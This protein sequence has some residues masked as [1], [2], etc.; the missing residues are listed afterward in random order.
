MTSTSGKS[1]SISSQKESG[2]SGT[3][4]LRELVDILRVSNTNVNRQSECIDKQS[5]RIDEIMNQWIECENDP[6]YDY[7]YNEEVVKVFPV[8][9]NLKVILSRRV[10]NLLLQ[11]LYLRNCKVNSNNLNR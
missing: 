7:E 5:Q 6:Q 8:S 2:V 3:P 1:T 10:E 4:P 9:L 11:H